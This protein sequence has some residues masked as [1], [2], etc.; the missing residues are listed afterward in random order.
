[1]PMVE[2]ASTSRSL[3]PS[4]N[5]ALKLLSTAIVG[6]YMYTATAGML[7]PI[8]QR[9]ILFGFAMA[10][11]FILYAPFARAPRWLLGVD[12]LAV[13]L[14]IGAISLFVYYD[15]RYIRLGA[16]EAQ[17]WQFPIALVFTVMALEASRRVMGWIMPAIVVA[18]LAYSFTSSSWPGFF[19]TLPYNSIVIMEFVALSTEGMFGIIAHIV[20]TQIILFMIFASFLQFSGG[21]R[22]FIDLP[23]AILGRVRGGPAKVA[24]VASALFGAVSGSATANVVG[25]GTFTIPLMKKIGYRPA[26]AGA[27]EACASTGGQLMPPVMGA[28][29]FIIAQNLQV[30]YWDVVVAAFVPAVL[31]YVALYSIVDIKAVK[32]GMKGVSASALPTVVGTLRSHGYLA[33]PLAMLV[34]LLAVTESTPMFASFWATLAMIALSWV[35]RE[36]RMTPMRILDTCDSCIRGSL[37]VILICG[38]AGII[39]GILNLTGLGFKLSIGMFDLSGG[40]VFVLLLLAAFISYVLGMGVTTTAIYILVATLTAPALTKIGIQPMAAHLAVFYFGMLSCITPPVAT[41]VYAAAALAKEDFWKVGWQSVR[42]GL[43]LFILPFVFIFDPGLILKGESIDI[44]GR[45]LF[46]TL[47]VLALTFVLEGCTYWGKTRVVSRIVFGVA[48]VLLLIPWPLF[49]VAG[50]V[51]LAAAVLLHWRTLR[52]AA[53]EQPVRK[54]RGRDG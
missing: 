39:V 20:S 43:V 36:N 27:I 10:V 47:G 33:I 19:H 30:R 12:I 2:E 26:E 8:M 42:L 45:I 25:T 49:D 6:L 18:F 38:I 46:S 11:V 50:V 52:R 28:A 34:Y 53:E 5:L 41:A 54:S 7:P 37:G 35:R 16:F 23:M 4:V 44:L 40:N 22:F 24:V 9:S 17:P 48:C 31:F 14:T 32:L 13:L 3:S 29:A 21:S 51:A 1:M 15:Q